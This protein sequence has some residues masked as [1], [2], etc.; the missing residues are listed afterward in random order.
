MLNSRQNVL[1]VLDVFHLLQSNHLT[2]IHDLQRV[3]FPKSSVSGQQHS[4]KSTSTY[5]QHEESQ[6]L[7]CQLQ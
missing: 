5:R 6:S 4:A 2:D 3:V 7:S 1:L